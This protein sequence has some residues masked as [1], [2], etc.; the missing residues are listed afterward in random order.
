MTHVTTAV[1]DW[2]WAHDG[3]PVEDLAW[4]EWIIRMHHP[5]VAGHLPE[6]F[7]AYGACPS[8]TRRRDAMLARCDEFRTMVRPAGG[9]AAGAQRWRRNIEITRQWQESP[10]AR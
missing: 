10:D 9:A 4:C 2:E 3:D 1:V 6:L 5:E 8:W 7:G